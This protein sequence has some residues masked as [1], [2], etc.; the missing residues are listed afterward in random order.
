MRE[1]SIEQAVIEGIQ[2]AADLLRDHGRSPLFEQAIGSLLNSKTD[3]ELDQLIRQIRN[4]FEA[5]IV[6]LLLIQKPQVLESCRMLD[7]ALQLSMGALLELGNYEAC[8]KLAEIG[9]VPLSRNISKH[10]AAFVSLQLSQAKAYRNLGHFQDALHYYREALKLSAEFKQEGNLA[11]ILL[12]I[13]KVHGNYLG[14]HSLFHSFVEEARNRVE[15]AMQTPRPLGDRKQCIRTL[16]IC[17]DALGQAF[18]DSEPASAKYHFKEALRLNRQIKRKNGMCRTECHLAMLEYQTAP[19]GKKAAIFLRFQNLLETLLEDQNEERGLG[20][21]W[22]QYASMLADQ[23]RLTD[24]LECLRLGENIALR[25]SDHRTLARILLLRAKLMGAGRPTDS[26]RLLQ[27]AFAIARK[28]NLLLLESQIHLLI[29]NL[30]VEQHEQRGEIRALVSQNRDIFLRLLKEVGTQLKRFSTDTLVDPEI[31]LLSESTRHKFYERIL[32]D[33]DHILAQLDGNARTLAA[34]LQASDSRQQELLVFGI[35][36]CMARDLLHTAKGLIP[37]VETDNRL[38]AVSHNLD[39]TAARLHVLAQSASRDEAKEFEAI[40]DQLVRD[41]RNIS[42]AANV[43]NDLR[44]MLSRGLGKPREF[45]QQ[46]RLSECCL[47]ACAEL[48]TYRPGGAALVKTSFE[49]EIIVNSNM[50]LITSVIRNLLIN[51]IE[52]APRQNKMPQVIHLNLFLKRSGDP[53]VQNPSQDAFLSVIAN[54]IDE[55]QAQIAANSLHGGLSGNLSSKEFGSGV[56]LELTRLVFEFLLGG[57]LNMVHDTTNVGLQI[58]FRLGSG[59]A[60]V[61]ELRA[62]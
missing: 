2:T 49:S 5:Y 37:Q 38:S 44:M 26:I 12:L 17:H 33:F 48:E 23:S 25:Y 42:Q 16:A 32:F 58:G 24:A 8:L 54:Y 55:V 6:G 18:R 20:V 36:N 52:G 47:R 61:A 4:I 19:E 3:W 51:A 28:H 13:G 11:K 41:A 53:R 62:E 31:Q 60:Q 46:V 9:T 10:H 40:E 29:A 30:V 43:L 34:A 14:Q 57:D 45:N 50:E 35:T 27:Q 7:S 56:G 39:R 15:R 59:K 1:S 22:M 21:R